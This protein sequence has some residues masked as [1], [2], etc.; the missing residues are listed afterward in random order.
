MTGYIF[1]GCNNRFLL[2][3]NIEKK[4]VKFLQEHATRL[5][6]QEYRLDG[7]LCLSPDDSANVFMHI[8][9]KD[10]SIA[11]MCGNGVRIVAQYLNMQ[12]KK[13]NKCTI[14]T[15][16]GVKKVKILEN[17]GDN[18][19]SQVDMG[20]GI[21]TPCNKYFDQLQTSLN[22]DIV[23]VGNPHAIFLPDEQVLR[24]KEQLYESLQGKGGINVE[25]IRHIDNQDVAI[26]VFER[27]CGETAACGTGATAVAFSLQSK[28]YG[29][30]FN[31][32]MPGGKVNV[33]IK[34]GRALLTGP[35]TF[36]KQIDVCLS[37]SLPTRDITL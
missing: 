24:K 34:E 18:C 13:Q 5:C 12:D 23:D 30:Q 3:D 7:I 15:L 22:F 21:V 20:K 4:N 16:S 31:I 25:F 9:N 27:G 19:I 26:R 28:G 14:N 1:N 11:K 2:L 35:T 29:N 10:G 6:A 33:K 36:E 32:L 8:I 17:Q 37:P